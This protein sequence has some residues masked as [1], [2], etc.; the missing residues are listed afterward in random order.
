MQLKYTRIV[1]TLPRFLFTL[2][3]LAFAIT[4]FAQAKFSTVVNERHPG[5][6]DYIQVEYTVENARSV[7]K[8]EPPSFKNFRII[9]GPI[10]SSG[11]SI[12]NGVMS[13]YKSL[14]YIL[15]PMV[16][17]R[18]IIPGTSAVIDGKG[19]Q[20]EAIPIEVSKKSSGNSNIGGNGVSPSMPPLFPAD[21]PEVDEE[22]ILRSNESMSDKI[23]RNLLVKSDVN[24]AT[25]F[26][27]EPIVATF[28]L[29]SRLRSES[30]VLKRPSLNGFSVVDM[31]D[32]EANKPTVQMING[33]AF[34]VHIIRKTQ[35]FPLQA[36]NFEIDPVELEN[37][38][39]FIKPGNNDGGSARSPMQ[40][41]LDDFMSP[42]RGELVEQS[43]TL[44]S[45]P[46]A[47]TVKPLPSLNKPASFN[48]AVGK[49]ALKVEGKKKTLSVGEQ[50]TLRVEI[51]GQGNFTMIN[52]VT[53][54]L[55]DGMEVYDPLVKEDVDK[56]IYPLS[57]YKSFTYTVV[58]KDT[59]NFLIPGVSFSYFDPADAKYK[60]I[61]TDSFR[62]RI[63]PSIKKKRNLI[64][65]LLTPSQHNLTT[66][67]ATSM[68]TITMVALASLLFACLFG[69]FLWA[70]TRKNKKR[71]NDISA[72]PVPVQ[73]E[74]PVIDYSLE[75]ARK[76]MNSGNSQ[77]F[78]QEINHTVWKELQ[79]NVRLAPADLNKF[80]AVSHLQEKGATPSLIA[81][82]QSVLND[83]E[84]AL[85]TPVHAEADMQQTLSKAEVLIEELRKTNT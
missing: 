2:I 6:S 73:K 13:Q 83:C 68:S 28:R 66:G 55:P 44:G 8:I 51:R 78:Y 7:E 3:F 29:C 38:V 18:L 80:N 46:I 59:G 5:L 14:A 85:Y 24:K 58:P 4:N 62:L 12:M 23:R 26:E 84:I 48:G 82:L 43:F 79:Q 65:K 49:F 20:S 52:P 16:T 32:P 11:M 77:Q 36:G 72:P 45:K 64:A 47:I 21:E 81:Q 31:I 17:G 60:T 75:N 19:F 53:L 74:I 56:T 22:Y 27:G 63:T 57:G 40:Q 67:E 10:Q 33:K 41:F 70:K 71:E 34:N 39:K 9:Q 69:I 35:L 42:R 25:C 1:Q 30:K 37:T 61:T 50:M 76:A 15:Q 54:Q